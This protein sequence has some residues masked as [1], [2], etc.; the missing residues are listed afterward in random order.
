MLRAAIIVTIGLATPL[1]EAGIY[2]C[3]PSAGKVITYT[4]RPCPSGSQQTAGWGSSVSWIQNDGRIDQKPAIRAVLKQARQRS[5]RERK[6]A[7]KVRRRLARDAERAKAACN[8]A[9][10]TSRER[11]NAPRE[12]RRELQRKE[13]EACH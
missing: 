7:T 9:R 8:A 1:A 13:F 5:E 2:K 4:D 12:R 11:W 3:Q 10:K 6:S